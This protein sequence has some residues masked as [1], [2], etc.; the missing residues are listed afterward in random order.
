VLRQDWS[1]SLPIA[2]PAFFS[3]W[4]GPARDKL[5][6]KVSCWLL[7]SIAM[8]LLQN[9]SQGRHPSALDALVST[10]GAVT[11]L[12]LVLAFHHGSA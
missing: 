9:F 5:S 7:L 6:P 11:G 1:I 2:G 8:E 10:L 4:L 12:G 3:D